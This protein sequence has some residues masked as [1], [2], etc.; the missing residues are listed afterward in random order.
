MRRFAIS[1]ITAYAL[2]SCAPTPPQN[3]PLAHGE[4]YPDYRGVTVPRA[5]APLN[6]MFTSDSVDAWCASFKTRGETLRLGGWGRKVTID[7]DDWRNLMADTMAERVDVEVFFRTG[8][9]FRRD[10]FSFS[11]S[12]D[13]FDPYVTYRLIEPGY[14]VWNAIQIEERDMTS[15]A[16]RILADNASLD[17][18]CM[19]CHLHGQQGQT[20]L[21]HLRGEGGG[22]ML[23]RGGELRKVTLRNDSM[24]G[25]A[26]Y[27]EIDS[28]GR[29]GVFSTNVIIPA[30]H[31][32]GS[33]RLEVYDTESDLCI[34]DFDQRRMILSPLVRGDASLE[35]FPC[36]APDGRTVY[37]CS[38]PAKP[39]PD[40][41]AT[42]RYSILSIGFDGERWAE[43]VDTVWSAERG[44]GS[45]SFPKVSP[46]GRFLLFA[47][48]A[49]GTFPIWHRETDLRMLDLSDG[50]EVDVS[51][52]N[53]C[54]SES[55]HTWASS[56]RWVVF[57]SKRGDGQY[58]RVFVAHV[59]QDGRVGRP[60][61]IPQRD[62][63]ADLLCLK[64][65]N[66]PDVSPL[67]APF[68][69]KEVERVYRE[70]SAI[71]FR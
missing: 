11:I 30:L 56:G 20:T 18:K 27:G 24:K 10:T 32:Q 45:A 22:T 35:T 3:A 71:N 37:F 52:L 14:E 49:S 26:V 67:P 4:T 36:F 1:I 17:G 51:R 70:T 65:Y 60:F 15:F 43:S 58:G 6:F 57:A 19:N 59:G 25:G 34:A 5:I 39:V 40:S 55:Y 50:H 63:E 31:S 2:A 68:G 48:S 47:C 44:G 54:V 21:F 29:Y 8:G 9:E 69:R 46:D 53:S 7:E 12:D 33:R 23:A 13:A 61:V 28:S 64:S 62:P 42:L 16:T 41:I 38:A 66:I